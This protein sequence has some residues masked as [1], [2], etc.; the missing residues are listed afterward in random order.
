MWKG[1]FEVLGKSPVFI[2]D[3]AHNPHGIKAAAKSFKTY[4]PDKKIH[5]IVGAMADKD[6]NAMMSLLV[7][8]SA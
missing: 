8:L 7:P 4:F 2:L 5:F 6:I 3:G 1:R